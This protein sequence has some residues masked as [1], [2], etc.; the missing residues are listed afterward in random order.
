[1]TF[2]RVLTLSASGTLTV[3]T[4]RF[5]SSLRSRQLSANVDIKGHNLPVMPFVTTLPKRS[6]FDFSYHF[7][8]P[9]HHSA[10]TRSCRAVNQV[11]L[12]TRF[13]EIHLQDY[14]ASAVRNAGDLLASVAGPRSIH[15]GKPMPDY[16]ES[17]RTYVITINLQGEFSD[18]FQ[19][20]S[21]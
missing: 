6:A 1:M 3:K 12:S 2:L 18:A 11:S 21:S 9:L 19:N 16:T 17:S 8:R 5:G 7:L 20:V 4:C 14:P 13:K 15:S 10:L